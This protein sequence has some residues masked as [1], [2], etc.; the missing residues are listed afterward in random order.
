MSILVI[1]L[2]AILL[3]GIFVANFIL[4]VDLTIKHKRLAMIEKETIEKLVQ[5]MKEFEDDDY[6]E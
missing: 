4:L 1:R 5:Q 6:D 3:G 2:S